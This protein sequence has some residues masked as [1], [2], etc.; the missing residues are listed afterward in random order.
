MDEASCTGRGPRPVLLPALSGR[1]YRMLCGRLAPA[2]DLESKPKNAYST[3]GWVGWS[4]EIGF[5]PTSAN[6]VLGT[7]MTTDRE[8]PLHNT[9]PR[10]FCMAPIVP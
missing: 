3:A 4:Q 1:T 9:S 6:E 2:I 7:K 8:R 10:H 5:V